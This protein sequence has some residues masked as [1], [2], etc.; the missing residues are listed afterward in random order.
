M[1]YERAGIFR[2]AGGLKQY[3]VPHFIQ[4]AGLGDTL[5]TIH[6]EA[7]PEEKMMRRGFLSSSARA[8]MVF[9]ASS[10]TWL[11]RM[12]IARKCTSCGFMPCR[13]ACRD[14]AFREH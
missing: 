5:S 1:A 9:R 3:P 10:S 13:K 8:A 4:A 6:V 12:R 7:T 14:T 11:R 2:G